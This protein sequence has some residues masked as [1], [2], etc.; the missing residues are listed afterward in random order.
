LDPGT[1]DWYLEKIHGFLED[2]IHLR[3]TSFGGAQLYLG[4]YISLVREDLT[5]FVLPRQH[6]STDERLILKQRVGEWLAKRTNILAALAAAGPQYKKL[7]F[8][9]GIG[10]TSLPPC[11]NFVN[12]RF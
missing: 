11:Y 3:P 6:L 12:I 9:L 8:F 10:Y 1:F 4:S 7:L 2:P 5:Y